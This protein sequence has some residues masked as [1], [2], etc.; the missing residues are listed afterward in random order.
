MVLYFKKYN[1]HY[2]T[3]K[4]I[5]NLNNVS[6]ISLYIYLPIHFDLFNDVLKE[7][8]N[9]L[10]YYLAFNIVY[11]YTCSPNYFINVKSWKL[12]IKVKSYNCNISSKS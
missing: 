10:T 1:N 9:L 12:K 7:G 11:H 2:Y 3:E 8:C 5:I 4:P 6:Y